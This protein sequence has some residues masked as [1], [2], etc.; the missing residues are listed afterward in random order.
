[1]IVRWSG[2]DIHILTYQEVWSVE[3]SDYVQLLRSH[4]NSHNVS[5]LPIAMSCNNDLQS[6]KTAFENH[7]TIM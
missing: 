2:G 7:M 6:N 1:M 4:G 5:W 3:I